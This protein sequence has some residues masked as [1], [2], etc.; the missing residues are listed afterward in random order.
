VQRIGLTQTRRLA[1]TG[2]RID[3]EEAAQLGLV[4]YACADAEAL[5]AINGKVVIVSKQSIKR[6]RLGE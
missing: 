1:L 4:H 5:E 6:W 2:A 3:G